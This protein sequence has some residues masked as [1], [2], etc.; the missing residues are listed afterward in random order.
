MPDRYQ[1]T[2][3]DEA[4]SMVAAWD[5]D[6]TKANL[7][8]TVVLVGNG[9]FP[10][11]GVREAVNMSILWEPQVWATH[12]SRFWSGERAMCNTIKSLAKKNIKWECGRRAVL[13]EVQK[14]PPNVKRCFDA[15]I[16]VECSDIGRALQDAM[17]LCM[18]T[19]SPCALR[20]QEPLNR[21]Y[22]VKQ[23]VATTLHAI[24]T[25]HKKQELEHLSLYAEFVKDIEDVIRVL[26][27]ALSSYHTSVSKSP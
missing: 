14:S 25:E 5:A 4:C 20:A 19:K 13:E 12:L 18:N 3:L 16:C 24:Q 26:D 6:D 23:P 11:K 17:L 7:F 21:K 22:I 9:Y 15:L 8:F 2:R 10:L 1:A 27:D